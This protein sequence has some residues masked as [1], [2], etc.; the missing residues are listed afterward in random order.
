[1]FDR[2]IDTDNA[3]YYIGKITAIVSSRAS[4]AFNKHQ[5]VT[6]QDIISF[7]AKYTNLTKKV[8]TYPTGQ[9]LKT[10]IKQ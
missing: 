4:G 6:D 5:Y 7:L 2:K 8:E 3:Q 1:M 9:Q 10:R